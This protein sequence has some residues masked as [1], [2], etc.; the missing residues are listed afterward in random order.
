MS[1]AGGVDMSMAHKN[2]GIDLDRIKG[3]FNEESAD[4]K[5]LSIES[6]TLLINAER[7]TQLREQ[8][9][10]ELTELQERQGQVAKL[11]TLLQK[12]NEATNTKGELDCS[13]NK[14]LQDLL[15]E[16]KALGVQYKDGQAKFTKEERDRLVENIRLTADDMNVKN[17]MQLQTVNRLTNE[18][19][20]CFQLAKSIFKPL[21]EAKL[22]I[23]RGIKQ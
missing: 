12:V 1:S 20:E 5:Q 18:R 3:I 6:L 10:K 16:G 9:N 13:S 22:Q 7:L 23:I 2:N 4:E 8:T 15:K 14:E 11:H 17:E 19:F 21:H